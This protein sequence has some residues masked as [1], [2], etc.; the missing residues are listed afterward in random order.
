MKSYRVKLK[1]KSP[2][3]IGI[4][5]GV[6]NLTDS[7]IHSDTLFS[8]ITNAYNLLYGKE[9]TEKFVNKLLKNPE[10]FSL[11]SAFYY[12]DGKYF[13]PK[14]LGY[15]FVKGQGYDFK[16]LKKVKYVSEEILIGKYDKLIVDGIFASDDEVIFP[17]NIEERPRIAVDRITN[18]T[19]IYY[20]SSVRFKENAGL[21][22]VLD[23]DESLEKEILA[24][25]KLLSDEGLGGE[26]TYGLGN[27]DFELE[28]IKFEQK[29]DSNYLLLSLCFPKN[30]EEVSKFKYYKL[31]EK[32]GFIYS[33]YDST[34]RQPLIRFFEEGSVLE[35]RIVGKILDTTPDLFKHK[36]LK[37]GRAYL[38][39]I[40]KGGT[41]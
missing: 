39:P 21:W 4:K 31:A 40:N 12:I 36:V 34:K 29:D 41:I 11:S 14:P 13:Y 19:N 38:I 6:Y 16:K 9:K 26:R 23:V 37:F 28:E 3:H 15:R 17:F 10:V 18:E 1:F 2:F 27:F 33:L 30:S 22:F 8:G 20:F 32:T 24:S 5:E 25:L 35:G 7:I